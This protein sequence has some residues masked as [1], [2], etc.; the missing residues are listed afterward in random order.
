MSR[1]T[2]TI[3]IDF[4]T[5]ADITAEQFN[6]FKNRLNKMMNDLEMEIDDIANQCGFEAD[7]MHPAILDSIDCDY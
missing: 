5:G 4:E 7:D 6:H 2:G 3:D 1:I